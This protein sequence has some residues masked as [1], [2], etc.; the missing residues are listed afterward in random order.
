MWALFSRKLRVWLF[1]TVAAPVLARVLGDVGRSLEEQRGET[2]LTRGLRA[3]SRWLERRQRGP[4]GRR[5][6]EEEAARR[7]ASAS[8]R[9]GRRPARR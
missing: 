7:R 1:F 6:R 2:G 3:G 9:R 4:A 5:H 8:G